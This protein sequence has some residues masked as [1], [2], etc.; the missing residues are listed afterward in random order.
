M[1]VNESPAAGCNVWVELG[2]HAPLGSGVVKLRTL[3][4]LHHFHSTV[5]G[6]E[7]CG[8]LEGVIPGMPEKQKVKKQQEGKKGEKK[9]TKIPLLHKS[10]TT[11]G[12]MVSGVKQGELIFQRLRMP[13]SLLL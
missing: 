2:L 7:I 8:P 12:G 13:A 4:S 10:E 3:A 5:K 1:V 9:W 6:G 11:L